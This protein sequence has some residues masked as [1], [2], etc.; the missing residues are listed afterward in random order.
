MAPSIWL[1]WKLTAT[2]LCNTFNWQ[3]PGFSSEQLLATHSLKHIRMTLSRLL[4]WATESSNNFGCTNTVVNRSPWSSPIFRFIYSQHLRI[5]NPKNLRTTETKN[6][7]NVRFI[8]IWLI[9]SASRI[10]CNPFDPPQPFWNWVLGHI[11][12]WVAP[13]LITIGILLSLLQ[14]NDI[15]NF[16]EDL[17]Y[18]KEK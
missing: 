16:D 17:F 4:F 7:K 9:I 10:K 15:R 5:Q 13:N 11:P 18:Q 1:F 3:Y 2:H 12:L 8:V 6:P 14:H